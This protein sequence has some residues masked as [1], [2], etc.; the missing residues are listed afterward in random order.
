[1]AFQIELDKADCVLLE[2]RDWVKG[3]HQNRYSYIYQ[4]SDFPDEAIDICVD[5][6]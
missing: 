5:E 6:N 1:M 3:N 2:M 4:L